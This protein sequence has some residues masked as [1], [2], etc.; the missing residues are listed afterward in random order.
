MKVKFFHTC[1]FIPWFFLYL[2]SHII[3]PNGYQ[4]YEILL[5]RQTHIILLRLSIIYS[6]VCTTPEIGSSH[7][8]DDGITQVLWVIS[9]MCNC[10]LYKKYYLYHVV[11][12]QLWYSLSAHHFHA[13]QNI[14]IKRK[15][16]GR[17]KW[18]GFFCSFFHVLH[19]FSSRRW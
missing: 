9:A 10:V 6:K 1:I 15:Q 2:Y 17:T 14:K 8:A 3:K 7:L 16:D 18:S 5:F 12:R 11:R 19:S 13:H 4:T